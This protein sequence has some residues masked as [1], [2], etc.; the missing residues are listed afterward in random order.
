MRLSEQQIHWFRQRRS[1]LVEPFASPEIA[2]RSL[3]GVQAQILTAAMLALWNRS[4]AG[5]S[6]EGEVAA[7][8]FEEKTLLRLWGQRHTLHLYDT[9]DWPL[10]HAAH[11]HRR[12]WWERD[13][14]RDPE[15]EIAAFR[16]G[17]H[18]AGELLRQRGTLSRKELRAS[19]IPLP[20]AL[21]SPWGG[22]FAELVRIG[23]ACHAR[24]DGGEARYA[25]R[26]H[27]LPQM[28]WEPPTAD[29]A[30]LELAR[31]YFRCYGPAAVGDLAYWRGATTKDAR[32]WVAALEGEVAAVECETPQGTSEMLLLAAD[33]PVATETPPEREAWPVRMLGRFDPLLLAH[34]EKDWVVP[35]R[36]L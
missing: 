17:V 28:A 20:E 1:G 5:A 15:V 26:E 13:A 6:T 16:E 24:W 18:R 33:L 2:A 7:R 8:L 11:A 3:A 35:P 31:R 34:R 32:R 29:S 4:A 27:W 25:H 12:T 23:E 14:E 21:L 36:R 22:V 10:I 19:G 30:H 9:D